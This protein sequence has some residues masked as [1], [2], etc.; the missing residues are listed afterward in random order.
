MKDQSGIEGPIRDHA[1]YSGRQEKVAVLAVGTPSEWERLGQTRPVSGKMAFVGFHDVSSE[2]IERLKPGA[3]VSPLL[4]KGFD[5]ID[6]SQLLHNLNFGGAYRAIAHDLPNP[7][8]VESEIAQ[9]CPRL[10]FEIVTSV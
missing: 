2:L 5:C 10:D 4:A 3:I 1:Y 9:L 7:K 8:L 6:L